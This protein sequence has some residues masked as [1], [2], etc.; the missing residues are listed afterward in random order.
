MFIWLAATLSAERRKALMVVFAM[1]QGL[2]ATLFY[3]YRTLY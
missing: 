1:I 2:A 3:T